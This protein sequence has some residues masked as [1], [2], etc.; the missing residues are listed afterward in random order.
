MF[1]IVGDVHGCHEELRELL[2]RLGYRDLTP[3]EGRSL[4]LVGD[5][6]DRG[7]KVAE[8]LDLIMRME[9]AGAARCVMGNHDAK[10]LR[11]LRGRPVTISH[12]LD[13]SIEQL[14]RMPAA[15]RQS[16]AG[17]LAA[18][19]SH[20][21]LDGG[22][23]VVAHAGLP[24]ELHGTESSRVRSFALYG[25]PTGRYDEHGLPIRR[26]WAADYR[27]EALVVY[28]H[29]PLVEPQWVN[30]T[31]NIDTG[32]VFGGAL[33]ALRYPERELIQVNARRVY[34]PSPRIDYRGRRRNVQ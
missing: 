2:D 3:P 5:L 8:V 28:G 7:P 31:I 9:R 24:E 13:A 15:F 16:A 14:E 30:G 1:D 6:V 20:L 18:M 27:G 4:V 33:T 10:L 22:R 34:C 32:C 19:P 12:G 23:L 17:Y 25:D 26:D 29:T 21:V 11:H